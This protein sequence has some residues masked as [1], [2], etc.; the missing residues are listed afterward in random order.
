M[1]AMEWKASGQP[2]PEQPSVAPPPPSEKGFGEQTA[3][4]YKQLKKAA[5]EMGMEA[6]ALHSERLIANLEA[7]DEELTCA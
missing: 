1:H 3:M 6:P 5:C 7:R 2:A 4:L